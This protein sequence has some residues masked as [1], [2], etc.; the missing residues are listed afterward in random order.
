MQRLAILVLVCVALGGC[1]IGGVRF[2]FPGVYRIDVAQGNIV[3]QEMIDRL[4]PGMTK[5]QVRFIMGTPLV[6]DTFETER[7]DYVYSMSRR[8]EPGSEKRVSLYFEKDALVR[9]SGDFTPSSVKA[10][11]AGEQSART[12]E[13]K[14]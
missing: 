12:P 11:A 1:G 9:F 6:V 5:R 14:N 4:Q 10:A 8:G 2:G 7:W 3:T 13:G